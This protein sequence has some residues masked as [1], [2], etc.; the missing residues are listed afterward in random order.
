M[1]DSLQQ[2]GHTRPSELMR[3]ATIKM[4]RSLMLLERSIATI[5]RAAAVVALNAAS[6]AKWESQTAEASNLRY[7]L[8]Q[9]IG[10]LVGELKANGAT[11]EEVLIDIKQGISS[12][13]S[14][15]LDS[16][17]ARAVIAQA[18]QWAIDA[19]YQAA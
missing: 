16:R 4:A 14:D 11:P 10:A 7:A 19:Y 17:E 13:T 12:A 3:S 2:P 9:S 1:S 15:V 5:E 8:Q 6:R 18:V